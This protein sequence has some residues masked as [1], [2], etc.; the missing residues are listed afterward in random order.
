MESKM[1]TQVLLKTWESS[2]T[3][4]SLCLLELRNVLEEVNKHRK[5]QVKSGSESKSMGA[6][7]HIR[8]NQNILKV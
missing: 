2:S 5:K 7:S 1:L 4:K 8:S 3:V 6:V